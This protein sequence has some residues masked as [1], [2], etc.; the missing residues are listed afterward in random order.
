MLLATGAALASPAAALALVAILSPLTTLIQTEA[1]GLLPL[2]IGQL[3]VAALALTWSLQH[4]AGA[5]R[6]FRPRGS[7]LYALFVVF[8]AAISLN[9]FVASSVGA[10]FTEWLKWAIMLLLIALILSEGQWEALVF[11]LI[12]SGLANAIVGLYIFFGG[13]GADHLVI[14]ELPFRAFRAFGTFGQPNPFSGFLGL[15]TPLALGAALAYGWCAWR[16]WQASQRLFTV[17]A[18]AAIFYAGAGAVMGLGV[19][20]S[21]SRGAWLGLAGALFALIVALPRKT[22]HSALLGL[23]LIGLAGAIWISGVLPASITARVA[24]ATAELFA[25]T[26]VRNV[27]ITPANYAV[28]ERLAHWQAALNMAESHPWL[29]VG[30]GNYEVVYNRYRLL[31]WDEPLGHAHNYYLNVLAETGMIGLLGYLILWIGVLVMTWRARRHPDA[32]ARF[33]VIGLFGTWT[34]LA[35]HSLTDKLYVNN[36]FLHIGIMLGVL[37]LLHRQ[38]ISRVRLRRQWRIPR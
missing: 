13:S 23:G 38:T 10:W 5:R 7:P 20:A 12:A 37:A 19:I 3:L 9:G 27:D 25:L 29:G 15:L 6:L 4:I 31:N 22:W 30:F 36:L 34:Y 1:P 35:V 2:E 11:A 17:S 28:V 14:G 24:S 8:F 16:S 18:V 26:E 32:A 21:W 33:V